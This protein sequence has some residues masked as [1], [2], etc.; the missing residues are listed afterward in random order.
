[1]SPAAAL[2][3]RIASWHDP[4]FGFLASSADDILG[5]AAHGT[6]VKSGT[7]SHAEKVSSPCPP[8][9]RAAAV[10]HRCVTPPRGFPSYPVYHRDDCARSRRHR[11][12]CVGIAAECH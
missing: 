6:F 11:Q 2:L 4:P 1:M 5:P 3:P 7:A 10:P 9:H 12:E 8:S